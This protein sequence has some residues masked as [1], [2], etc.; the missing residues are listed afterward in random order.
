[1]LFACVT[2]AVTPARLRVVDFISFVVVTDNFCKYNNADTE[3]AASG[4]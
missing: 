1:M 3:E 4:F 2:S